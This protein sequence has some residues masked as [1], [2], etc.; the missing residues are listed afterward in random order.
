MDARSSLLLYHGIPVRFDDVYLGGGRE[1]EP[2][3]VNC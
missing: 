1:I 2:D 3:I